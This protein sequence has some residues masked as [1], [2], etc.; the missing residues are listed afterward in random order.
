MST[1]K[2]VIPIHREGIS[3]DIK[4]FKKYTAFE[5]LISEVSKRDLPEN[6]I[7]TLNKEIE[8]LNAILEND[9]VF[10]KRLGK[11]KNTIIKILEKDLKIVPKF[12][13][14]RQ[15]MVLGMTIFGIPIGVSLGAGIDNYG[16]IGVGIAVGI[17]VGI[18]I[19]S[20]MDR[21]A[22]VEGRQLD[23]DV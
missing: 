16:M 23:I 11:A 22:E 20:E 13:Y 14:R 19:G 3:P 4:L 15:W 10:K 17:G 18:A 1:S 12:Y 5:N 9:K 21:K 2:I 6:V 8:I 7:T